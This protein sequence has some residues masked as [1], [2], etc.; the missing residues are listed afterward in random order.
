M[1]SILLR[2]EAEVIET[3]V[4]YFPISPQKVKRTS[5]LEGVTALCTLIRGRFR[6]RVPPEARAAETI[7]ET[8]AP[9]ATKLR[10]S[11]AAR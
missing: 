9:V 1:L 3:P 5:V 6:H 10:R 7:A 2:S 8:F 11:S 4:R